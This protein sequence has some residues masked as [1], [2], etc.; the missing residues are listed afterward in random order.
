MPDAEA[1]LF[2]NEVFYRAF[3]DRD[4]A[5]MDDLWSQNVQVSCIHPGWGSL[6]GREEVMESW[7]AIIENPDSPAILCRG[8]EASVYGE[9]AIVICYEQFGN[10][11]LIATNVFIREG[12]FWKMVHHQ[13]GPTS[14]T[15][16]ED[17]GG[18]E[19]VN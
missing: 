3:A 17:E 14:A 12:H 10:D 8:G 18:G 16:P 11:F 9:T 15:P 1:V 19:L 13:A 7:T 4:L 2:A 5:A 6:R